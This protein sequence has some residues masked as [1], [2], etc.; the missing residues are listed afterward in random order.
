MIGGS[1]YLPDIAAA[2][3]DSVV[4][5]VGVTGASADVEPTSDAYGYDSSGKEKWAGNQRFDL[6]H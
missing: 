4:I 5:A 3:T 6:L 2:M 1:A